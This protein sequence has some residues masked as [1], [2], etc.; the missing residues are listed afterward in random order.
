MATFE[1]TSIVKRGDSSIDELL[2]WLNDNIGQL[3]VK[4][5]SPFVTIRQDKACF[6]RHITGIGWHIVIDIK[7]EPEA[8]TTID[9]T[10]YDDVLATQAKLMFI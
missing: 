6:I 8:K 4:G 10:V 7:Y 3:V 1:I 9:L 5:D 2:Y